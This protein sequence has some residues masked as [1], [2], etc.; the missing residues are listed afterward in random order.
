MHKLSNYDLGLLLIICILSICSLISS[1]IFN[2]ERVSLTSFPN[3]W[4]KYANTVTV[5]YSL[6]Q[7]LTRVIISR[8][9]KHSACTLD[10][11]KGAFLAGRG[12][13]YFGHHPDL[14][15]DLHQHR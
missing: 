2:D 3:V 5:H 7:H 12:V 1:N 11:P 13:G 8:K 9:F 15:Q 14:Q 10:K 4:M 6:L